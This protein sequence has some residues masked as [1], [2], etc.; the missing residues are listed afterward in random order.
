LG[1]EKYDCLKFKVPTGIN[2]DCFDRYLLRV[3]EMFV[4]V[5]IITQT[6]Y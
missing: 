5:D 6:L 1:Y 3:E 2:G 4:S